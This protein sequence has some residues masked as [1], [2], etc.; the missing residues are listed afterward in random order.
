MKTNIKSKKF[1]SEAED[2]QKGW[3]KY[4]KSI[5][6]L[7]DAVEHGKDISL[8]DFRW[9]LY[10]NG[11]CSLIGDNFAEHCQVNRWSRKKMPFSAWQGM[12][13]GWYNS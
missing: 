6:K 2:M 5:D 10:G 11:W 8:N 9:V 4:L 7:K 13:D 1:Y 3:G 12:F